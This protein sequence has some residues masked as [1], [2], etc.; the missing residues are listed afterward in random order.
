MRCLECFSAK[1]VPRP[2]NEDLAKRFDGQKH[3][4]FRLVILFHKSPNMSMPKIVRSFVLLPTLCIR[5][6]C[7]G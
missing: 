4:I 3:K 6:V 2:E 1:L 5:S 7:I